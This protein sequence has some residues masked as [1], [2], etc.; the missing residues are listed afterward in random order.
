MSTPKQRIIA[1]LAVS[2]IVH[3]ILLWLPRIELPLAEPDLP[4]LMAK[5]EPI[6][7]LPKLPS[8]KKTRSKATVKPEAPA[9]VTPPIS[10][11]KNEVAEEL[12][13]SSLVT[14][15]SVAETTDLETASQVIG[16]NSLD[17]SSS[18][19]GTSSVTEATTAAAPP[20]PPLPKRARLK[21]EVRL[22]NNGM[23]IGDTVHTLEFED[24][25]Y[26]LE[27]TTKTIGLARLLKS[28]TL[29]QTS[30]GMSDGQ[31]LKPLKFSE[32]KEDENGTQISSSSF[33]RDANKII[34]ED[35]REV[36]L[37]ADTQDML[38]IL[39]Q[40]PPLPAEGDVLPIT[41]TNGRNLEKYRFEITTDEILNTSMG[42]LHTVHFRKL[43][44]A[45]KE[46]LEIWFSQE[47]RLLP[48]KVRHIEPNG[49]IGGE[50]IITEIRVSDN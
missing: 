42:K 38:S 33:D 7:R 19:A 11:E 46:G 13:Q 37:A 25:Q 18:V 27:S 29:T 20:R 5:L 15:S 28:Y 35:G 34:F 30:L 32:K 23:V 40:F 39:Y 16:N 3:A 22:G 4:P 21:F 12:P 17:I 2:L 41:V 1:A 44:P 48:V 26:K 45:G 10:P 6:N 14:A 43:Q 36:V 31:I 49:N 50:A 9:P 8:A 24:E 47:Y